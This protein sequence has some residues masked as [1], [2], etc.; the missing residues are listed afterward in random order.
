MCV[1]GCVCDMMKLAMC[2]VSE[3]QCLNIQCFDRY[4]IQ[5]ETFNKLT[6]KTEC[7]PGNGMLLMPLFKDETRHKFLFSIHILLF[8]LNSEESRLSDIS[9]QLVISGYQLTYTSFPKSTQ[10]VVLSIA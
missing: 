7:L 1:C 8:V 4:I 6:N 3:K 9:T 10:N 2:I 5:V